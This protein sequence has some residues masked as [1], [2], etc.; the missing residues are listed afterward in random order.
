MASCFPL[1]ER[2]K[3]KGKKHQYYCS[4]VLFLINRA[5]LFQM[6]YDLLST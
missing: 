3:S 1:A 4:L 2:G 6:L 5:L